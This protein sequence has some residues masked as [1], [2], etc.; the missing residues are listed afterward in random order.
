MLKPKIFNKITKIVS[1][2]GKWFTCKQKILKK[3]KKKEKI[4]EI[5]NCDGRKG[6]GFSEEKKSNFP[7][8]NNNCRSF[9][10]LKL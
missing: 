1:I 3:I 10:V 5:F 6:A 2:S 7:S 4:K 8:A 9:K